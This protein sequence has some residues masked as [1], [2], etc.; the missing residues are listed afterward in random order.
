MRDMRYVPPDDRITRRLARELRS[1]LALHGVAADLDAC[2]DALARGFGHE[3]YGALRRVTGRGPA[4]LPDDTA[5]P[6]AVA[7]RRAA[8]ADALVRL[9]AGPD[10]AAEI[11]DSLRPSARRHARGP[12]SRS[13]V[14]LLDV[15][16]DRCE[17]FGAQRMAMLSELLA[18]E[19]ALALRREDAGIA[20]AA[21]ERFLGTLPE[22]ARAVIRHFRE[23]RHEV[24]F[25]AAVLLGGF[26]RSHEEAALWAATLKE[27]WRR[28]GG[29]AVRI[30]HV[31]EAFSCG[32]PGEEAVAET[33]ARRRA[34]ERS[35]GMPRYP[36]PVPDGGVGFMLS[37][38]G[39]RPRVAI[40]PDF[41]AG[42]FME[43]QA[44]RLR[45]APGDPTRDLDANLG[46]CAELIRE[47]DG[48]A[49]G[50]PDVAR[51]LG[52]LLWLAL[53]HPRGGGRAL[54]DVTEGARRH[55]TMTFTRDLS[56]RT[57]VADAFEDRTR[58][59]FV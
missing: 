39:R 57:S 43:R 13:L 25:G 5:P 27:M 37:C 16:Q 21:A 11:L 48:L 15:T 53:V 35:L 28:L 38:A 18:R 32:I 33:W 6:E 45:G 7:A 44:A 34:G 54:A 8:Q 10:A 26:S 14:N 1:E 58:M 52:L 49:D 24:T 36:Q 31:A 56:I 59:L 55:V 2:L 40:V 51:D 20:S 17:P 50:H 47:L 3:T 9:G 23:G 42:G 19:D 12:G 46:L 41:A 22:N 30:G 4:T 29:G